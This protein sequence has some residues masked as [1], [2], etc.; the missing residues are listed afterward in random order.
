MTVAQQE[1]KADVLGVRINAIGWQGTVDA[2]MDWASRGES[3]SVCLC[4]VHSVVSAR[5]DPVFRRIIDSADLAT[6]DGAPIA[7]YLRRRGFRGQPRIS[8]AELMWACCERAATA[9]VPVYLYGASAAT[10]DRLAAR[11]GAAF[12]GIR[13]AGRFSPPFRV[14][15]AEED[16]RVI[17]KIHSSGARIV[18]V[19]LGC[20]KQEAWMARHRDRIGA[21]MIGVGAAFAFQAGVVRRAPR[22][23]RDAGLEWLHRLLSEPTRLWRRYLVTNSLFIAYVVLDLIRRP[24]RV[25]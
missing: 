23:M 24:R 4:N 19:A 8:G 2:I 25:T 11:I 3:R 6:P 14:L 13:L 12:P 15:T 5:R 16:E 21:V 7:W 20:P 17:R 18:F 10:L 22:W 1:S 9:G